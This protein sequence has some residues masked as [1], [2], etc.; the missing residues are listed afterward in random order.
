MEQASIKQT[1]EPMCAS[2]HWPL[3]EWRTNTVIR[4]TC[5][6]FCWSGRPCCYLC[7]SN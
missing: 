4:R 2:R 3:R 5:A 1:A 7:A 6:V